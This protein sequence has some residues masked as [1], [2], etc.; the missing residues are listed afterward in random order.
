MK[1]KNFYRTGLAIMVFMTVYVIFFGLWAEAIIN[2]SLPI[3]GPSVNVLYPLAVL[4]LTAVAG[5]CL[6]AYKKTWGWTV[7]AGFLTFFLVLTLA[8]T[9]FCMTADMLTPDLVIGMIL[10]ILA[11]G[12]SVWLFFTSPMRDQ[13]FAA[14]DYR[15][16]NLIAMTV[17]TAIV[18]GGITLFPKLS[19]IVKPT[20]LTIALGTVVLG[21]RWI[22]NIN[23]HH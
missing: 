12:A 14:E 22:M 5:L 15:I 1:V 8:G 19:R 3:N 21:I 6:Y 17:G 11:L 16:G 9:F 10:Q 13:F 4:T 2:D 23:K 18:I 20:V 7:C